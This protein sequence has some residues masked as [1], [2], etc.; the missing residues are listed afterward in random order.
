[1]MAEK[2]A[3]LTALQGMMR[4]N[5]GHQEWQVAKAAIALATA[6]ECV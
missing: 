2:E 3:L 6:N 1:M 5:A 4:D